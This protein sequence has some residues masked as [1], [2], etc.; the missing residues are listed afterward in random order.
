MKFTIEDSETGRKLTVEGDSAPTD[1]ESEELFRSNPAP[2][3]ASLD[4]YQK[5]YQQSG[6]VSPEEVG[7]T[8][9]LEAT[10]PEGGPLLALGKKAFEGVG[11]VA[12]AGLTDFI[13]GNENEPSNLKALF[14]GNE[15]P[16]DIQNR[17]LAQDNPAV[18]TLGK[19]GQSVA[20]TAPLL[21]MG[22][23]PSWANRLIAAGFSADMISKAP[24]LASD[25]GSELGKPPGER[26][27]DKLTS[28]ISD[29]IQTG[30]FA[31][32]AGAGAA[33]ETAKQ[34]LSRNLVEQLNK[35]DF[36]K[37]DSGVTPISRTGEFSSPAEL[38]ASTFDPSRIPT[39]G[40]LP[41]PVLPEPKSPRVAIPA[42]DKE[43]SQ[44]INVLQEI[45][46]NKADTTAK[47]Q[48][49]FPDSKLTREQAAELR[50]QAWDNASEPEPIKETPNVPGEEYESAP[51]VLESSQSVNK[52]PPV[53]VGEA[54][55]SSQPLKAVSE[56][57]A[58]T[59]PPA[60]TEPTT[61]REIEQ[62]SDAPQELVGMGGATPDEF[63]KGSV[64]PKMVLLTKFEQE[65]MIGKMEVMEDDEQ[66]REDS[67][68]KMEDVEAIQ[69]AIKEGDVSNLSPKQHEI[70]KIEAE[71]LAD[72]YA[73]N[74]DQEP[75]V[76]KPL[77]RRMERFI[78]KLEQ[79]TPKPQKEP[80]KI[81]GMGGAMPSEFDKGQGS[82][83]AMKYRLI[84][85]E[86]QQRG[87]EPLAKPESVSDQAVMDKA[88][89]MVDQNPALPDQLIKELNGK[90]RS[91]DAPERMV[92]LLHKIDLRN[93]YEKSARDAVQAYEDS[94]DYP[95]R[96]KDMAAHN[97]QTQILSDRLTD[98]EKASRLSGSE[99]GRGLR[100]LRIMANEDY[101]LASLETQLRAS[102]GGKPLTADERA[103]LMKIADDY[104]KANDELAS[105]LEQSKARESSLTESLN[106]A[107][108]EAKNNPVV[109]PH[110]RILADKIKTYFDARAEK[111]L[112]ELRGATWSIG[113][114]LLIKLTD[115]GVSKILSGS[116]DFAK[117]SADMIDALGE[118]IKPHLQTV[119]EASNNALEREA[120]HF[121]GGES[122]PKEK[123]PKVV[124][125]TKKTD[126]DSQIES[127]KARA[128]E[129]ASDKESLSGVAQKLAKLFIEKGITD[130]EKL[131]DEVHNALKE[132]DPALTRRD[133]M[134][135]ISGYGDFRQLSKEEVAVKLRGLKGEMQQVAKLQDM[136]EGVPPSKTGMER[137]TPTDEERRIIKAVNEAKIKFQVPITDPAT[138][139]KSALDTKKT[140]LENSIKDLQDRLDN[141]DYAKKPKRSL[142]LDRKAQELQAARD[143]VAKKFKAQQKKY[144]LANR[145]R[146]EKAFDFIS[147]AR[148]F[149][150][151][152]GVNVLAKLAAYSATKLPTMALGELVS[153]GLSKLP[154]VREAAA[155]APSEG[156]L[157]IRDLAQSVAKG[158]TKG[159]VDAYK[160]ATTGH[161]DIKSAFSDRSESGREWYNFFQTIHEVIKSPLRRTSFELSLA[162]RMEHAARNGADITDP[163]T[164]LALAKDAY[165]DSD[166]D[167]LLES[168]KLASGIRGVLKQ[169]EQPSKATG[170]VPLHGK[171]AATLGRLELPILS[172]PLNY[173]KQ[174]LTAAFGLVSGSY[175]LKSA[176]NRGIENLSPQEADA[177]IR[178]LKY[179]TIGG[180]MLLYGFYDG[181][182]NGDK[183]AFGGYYQPGEKRKPEQAGVGG[184]KLGT[185]KI[186]G[187]FL[188]NPVLAVGQ[189]GH[190]IGAIAASKQS[191][192][193]PEQRG[194]AVGTITG[195]LGLVNES[196]LGRTVESVSQLSDPR[197][198]DYALGEHIKGLA[199]PQLANEAAQFSDKDKNGNLIK[200]SPKNIR[201]HVETGIPG[202]RQTVPK[203]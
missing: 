54:P 130:R 92:L 194:L 90:P 12:R 43:P 122:A 134:D 160:T 79:A 55:A 57:K 183:G 39:A 124:R 50:R 106:Q 161:S 32:L 184:I 10:A 84:D 154:Y 2:P 51:P 143:S 98:L 65:E 93:A 172:V 25:L 14:S 131:I 178:H 173:A 37:A 187:L 97:V 7:N 3:R 87:L 118:R 62:V 144:E 68:I 140:Q 186:S 149:S 121:A 78:E 102:K 170:E 200:R 73:A 20:A 42:T 128:K 198:A 89:A 86:R 95:D 145:S 58:T 168:N 67:G 199:V 148:R 29:A 41:A 91:I 195:L 13:T 117:W 104:K 63:P 4:P 72:Q 24:K 113:P 176:F 105:H 21:A 111:A 133:T 107:K 147:N 152:S 174:T 23:L 64:A 156:G 34:R 139:L 18:A 59:E 35:A 46:Q 180:A 203:K 192:K 129:K 99:Q 75:D 31:P 80:P 5:A 125:A 101:S 127:A 165:L 123:A 45:R 136:A 146:T 71:N 9:L 76:Y 112:K 94:K 69:K 151:L 155:R 96:E 16:V 8:S 185:H 132:A 60:I 196:P 52:P 162:K 38:D 81:Q 202:L 66:L 26:D 179:G 181:Y 116:I 175:K 28:L 70:L 44:D 11:N 177:I 1:S 48:A 27:P 138:Q 119:F 22:A 182:K 53:R 36:S 15:L 188:H 83:T 40:N 82:P 189:L 49:L 120:K 77:S 135:A 190:T 56:D 153:G 103:S 193:N 159:I 197:S 158:L 167:L 137:R 141:N 19:V 164:Q 142:V 157:H 150:V 6:H 110:I 169:F 47:V 17:E 126:V 191:K 115:V 171:V 109:Q 88:M 166:R 85:Q 201:Q 100:A 114:E 61:D 33:S 74:I 30:V 108:T 163:M